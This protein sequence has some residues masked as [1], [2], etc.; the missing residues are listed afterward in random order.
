M[1][2]QAFMYMDAH[3]TKQSIMK[4]KCPSLN[5]GK[6]MILQNISRVHHSSTADLSFRVSL[7]WSHN[8]NH[9]LMHI[10]PNNLLKLKYPSLNVALKRIKCKIEGKTAELT[11]TFS[12][13]KIWSSDS[14][15]DLGIQE[16]L[17]IKA[18]FM[19]CIVNKS[20]TKK[21]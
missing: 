21:W 19:L 4:L 6:C 10:T 5:V 9:Q 17:L 2:H 8:S 7:G 12:N 20:S 14:S 1:K 18:S 3:Y 16:T 15:E 13:H 11:Q